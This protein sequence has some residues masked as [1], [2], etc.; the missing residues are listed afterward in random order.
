[1]RIK[2]QDH[3][4]P[5][6]RSGGLD[7]GLQQREMAAVLSVEIPDGQHRM[8]CVLMISQAASNLHVAI[9]V[10]LLI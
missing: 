5:A 4:R 9:A 2:G 7:D 1:M 6:F 8:C 10:R 3:G